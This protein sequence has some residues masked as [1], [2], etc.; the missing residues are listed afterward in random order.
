MND[1]YP[2][3]EKEIKL[4]KRINHENIIKFEESC[5]LIQNFNEYT[6]SILAYLFMEVASYGNL[7]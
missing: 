1:V 4:L 5:V 3:V 2:V 6:T 7:E